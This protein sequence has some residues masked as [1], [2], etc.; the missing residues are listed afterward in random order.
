MSDQPMVISIPLPLRRTIHPSASGPT[1]VEPLEADRRGPT[2]QRQ[3]PVGQVGSHGRE[4][5]E[6]FRVL[7]DCDQPHHVDR[8][9]VQVGAAP[10]RST[11]CGGRPSST[12]S[13]LRRPGRSRL[14]TLSP[15]S[16]SA[17]ARTRDSC[18]VGQVRPGDGLPAE[19]GLRERVVAF[20]TGRGDRKRGPRPVPKPQRPRRPCPARRVLTRASG[21]P[22]SC[23]GGAAT[24]TAGEPSCGTR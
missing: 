24:V 12:R 20:E 22:A 9:A 8:L 4:R 21:S 15:A 5:H 13:T 17:D 16:S 10:P 6:A 14:P 19:R 3:F 2:E 23:T 18:R 1:S 7:D 11:P